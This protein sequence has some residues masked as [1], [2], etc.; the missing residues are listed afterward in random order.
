MVKFR[1]VVVGI[2]CALAILVS[3]QPAAAQEKKTEFALGYQFLRFLEDGGENIPA[4]WGASVAGAMNDMIKVVGDVGG[5]YKDGGKLHTFQGGVEF[6]GKNPKVTPFGRVLAG[7]GVFSGD[8]D[9]DSVFVFTPEVGVKVMGS[10][11]VGGQFAVGFPI[12]R[13]N[14]FT[15]KTFRLFLGVTIR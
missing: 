15:E 14:G 6:A 9:S 3:V 1:S 13:D 4:G 10:G 7:V 2:L 5:H 11:R 12:M 8:G